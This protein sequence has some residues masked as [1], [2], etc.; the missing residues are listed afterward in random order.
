MSIIMG[1]FV[2]EGT[3][4]NHFFKASVLT[5]EGICAKYKITGTELEKLRK[6]VSSRKLSTVLFNFPEGPRYDM[7]LHLVATIK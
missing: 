4:D 5:S 1:S 7:L 3:P 2:S 6:E